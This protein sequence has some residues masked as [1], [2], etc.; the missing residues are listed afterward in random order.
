VKRLDVL[1]ASD[2]CVDLLLTGNVRPRFRQVEQVVDDYALEL[3]GSANIF[4]A[5]SRKLGAHVGVVGTVGPDLFGEFA[6]RRLGGLGVDTTRVR[7]DRRCR[8]GLGVALVEPDDRAILTVVGSI[9]GVAPGDL[10]PDPAAACRHWHVASYFLMRRL[11]P[12]WR[13]WLE[14]CRRA[15]VTTSL[16]TNWDPDERWDGV[17]ELL[18]FV[19][20]FLPNEAEAAALTGKKDPLAAAEDLARLGPL[21]VVKR[22]R[23]GA[24]AVRGRERWSREGR[25]ARAEAIVDAV[26]AGDNFDAG[27]LR[28]FRLGWD[29]DACLGLG[30]RCA[31]ASLRRA[32]GIEGQWRGKVRRRRRGGQ[33]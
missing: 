27:F 6:V 8:T 4:A 29:V 3:G 24:L 7:V 11:R 28:A 16:D 20:V 10:P 2:M 23:R 1:L 32:G 31:R 22:G 12:A 9:D 25:P 17:L 30:D 15:G 13:P 14:A 19:D 21:V 18:P 26:G 5:Q 33:P